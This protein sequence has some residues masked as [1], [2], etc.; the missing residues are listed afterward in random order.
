MLPE[1]DEEQARNRIA[2]RIAM[3]FRTGDVVNLGIG[4]PTLVSDFI[5]EE[6]QIVYQ[7]EN[8]AVGV[9]PK[10]E[11]EDLR[12]I[13]AG[14]RALSMLPGSSLI[15]SDFSFG[16]I[17]GGH[18]DYTVLGALQ[19]D[20][21]GNLANWWIPGKI[22][23]G[24]GGA[25]D[26]VTGVKTVIVGTLHRSKKG[27]PKLMKECTLPFTGVGVVDMVVTEYCVMQFPEGRMTLT[28][29]HPG[30]TE[31]ELRTVTEADFAVSS[32]L[33]EMAG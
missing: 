31:E 6:V 33:A 5:P 8:G 27:A 1:L 20:E 19:V 32:D 10:P 15:A 13:G 28:E 3:E 16:L 18:I 14:G 17:R 23:P 7:T 11:K 30:V 9:G 4:I 24:M 12:F 26:L 2:R 25:M 29:L 21:K 22:M